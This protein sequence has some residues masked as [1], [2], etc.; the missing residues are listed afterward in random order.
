M[1]TRALLT[2]P[3]DIPL[4]TLANPLYVAGDGGNTSITGNVTVVQ[5]TAASLNA[6]VVNA[7]AT[8]GTLTQVASSGTAGTILAANA[9]RKGASVFNDSTAILYL[10]LSAT[11]PTSSV[12]SVKMAAGSYFEAPAVYSGIIKGIWASANGNAVVTEYS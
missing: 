7:P 5:S 10:G 1:P 2:D 9:A 3:S 8:T 11:T 12:Y 4:G 6:T